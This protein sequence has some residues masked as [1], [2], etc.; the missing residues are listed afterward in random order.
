[1]ADD[2]ER[3]FNIIRQDGVECVVVGQNRCIGL[4]F[5]DNVGDAISTPQ[6]RHVSSKDNR[7]KLSCYKD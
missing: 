5:N 1:M 7:V 3:G 2:Q 4:L 6:Y